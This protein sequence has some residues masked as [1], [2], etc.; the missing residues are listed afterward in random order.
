M[1]KLS[2]FPLVVDHDVPMCQECQQELLSPVPPTWL[3]IVDPVNME[4]W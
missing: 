4:G 1:L 3:V 2:S